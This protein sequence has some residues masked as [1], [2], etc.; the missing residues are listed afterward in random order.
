MIMTTAISYR[1]SCGIMV[2]DLPLLLK[3]SFD[4]VVRGRDFTTEVGGLC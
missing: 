1:L 4:V 2:L 3:S